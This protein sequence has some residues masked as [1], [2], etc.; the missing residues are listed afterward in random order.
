[1]LNIELVE[2]K[3]IEMPAGSL[4][5]F[6]TV[7]ENLPQ[8]VTVGMSAIKPET[9]YERVKENIRL[10]KSF[11]I[12]RPDKETSRSI[13]FE[14]QQGIFNDTLFNKLKK[15]ISDFLSSICRFYFDVV[16]QPYLQRLPE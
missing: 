12:I 1:M 2:L 15:F 6:I 9:E 3:E 13:E 11:Q 5:K 10:L 14:K 4:Q 16:R 7:L 8:S